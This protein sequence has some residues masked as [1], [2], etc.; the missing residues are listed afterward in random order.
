M[1]LDATTRN[2]LRNV[3][4]QHTAKFC[5]TPVTPQSLCFDHIWQRLLSAFESHQARFAQAG[6]SDGGTVISTLESGQHYREQTTG[7]DM[8][9]CLSNGFILQDVIL[10]Q[11]CVAGNTHAL[12]FWKARLARWLVPTMSEF[13]PVLGREFAEVMGTVFENFQSSKRLAK[14]SGV[15]SLTSYLKMVLRTKYDDWDKQIK[16]EQGRTAPLSDGCEPSLPS[17]VVWQTDIEQCYQSAV[18]RAN[19]DHDQ[20]RLKLTS[21]ENQVL[22]ELVFGNSSTTEIA[23]RLRCLETVVSRTKRRLRNKLKVLYEHLLLEHAQQQG[24]DCQDLYARQQPQARAAFQNAVRQQASRWLAR[25]RQSTPA[26]VTP[27]NST[28]GQLAEALS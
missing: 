13:A 11:A 4:R 24:S 25:V 8:I 6:V 19:Q 3:L 22:Y 27:E 16:R 21:R 12:E 5:G 23:R 15:I 28:T 26:V 1:S 17:T 9:L 10:S 2:L 7:R 20:K 14:Y 18:R